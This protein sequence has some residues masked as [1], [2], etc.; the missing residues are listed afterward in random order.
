MSPADRRDVGFQ[1]KRGITVIPG[2]E[3]EQMGRQMSSMRGRYKVGYT[4]K[5]IGRSRIE[6]CVGDN[7]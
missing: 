1:S 7:L 4:L 2:S 5:F 6:V 3:R